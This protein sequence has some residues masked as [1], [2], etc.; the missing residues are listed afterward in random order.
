MGWWALGVDGCRAHFFMGGKELA[1]GNV[2]FQTGGH[3]KREMP[4]LGKPRH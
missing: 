2:R 3:P 1:V 4:T